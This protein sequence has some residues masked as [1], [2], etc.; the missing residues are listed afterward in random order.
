MWNFL[1]KPTGST[2]VHKISIHLKNAVQFVTV[3]FR[4]FLYSRLHKQ[5]SSNTSCLL[6]ASR[7]SCTGHVEARIMRNSIWSTVMFDRRTSLIAQPYTDSLTFHLIRQCHI[8][9]SFGCSYAIA[10]H[11][12]QFWE[13]NTIRFVV[14][15]PSL[16][17]SSVIWYCRICQH[18]GLTFRSSR[19]TVRYK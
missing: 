12:L 16:T 11:T 3:T 14:I 4:C 9:R 10:S 18:Q 8:I 5:R 7:W 13:R 15:C 1:N 17:E 6:R 2:I 19:K